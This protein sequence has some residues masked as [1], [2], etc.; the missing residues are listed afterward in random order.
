MSR[1]QATRDHSAKLRHEATRLRIKSQ[2]LRA[3]STRGPPHEMPD[4]LHRMVQLALALN[5][6]AD[7]EAY[8]YQFQEVLALAL[9]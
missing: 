9:I 5:L 6:A 8:L 2:L 1:Y 3:D 7:S 4:P